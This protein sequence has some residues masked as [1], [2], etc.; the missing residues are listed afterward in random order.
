MDFLILPDDPAAAGPAE[1]AAARLGPQVLT[2]ASG[3][4]WLAGRWAAEDLVIVTAGARRLAVFGRTRLDRDRTERA[5]ANA[6]SLRDLDG[7]FRQLPGAVHLVASFDGRIRAQGSLSTSRQVFHAELGGL[8]VAADSPRLL[9][10]LAGAGLDETTLALRLMVPAPPWPLT[11]RSVWRGV[12]QV[13]AGHWLEIEPAGRG[14]AVPWWT[15]PPADQPLAVVADRLREA[16]L[17]AVSVR[18]RGRRA[19]G[20]DLSGGLDSTSLCFLADAAGAELVTHHWKA[21]DPANDDTAWAERAAARL[22]GSRHRFVEPKDSPSW[23]ESQ[24]D[25]DDRADDVEGPLSWDRNR[26]HM[27]HQAR[28]DAAD[29]A[30]LHL[31]GIGGD[32]LFTTLPTYLWSLVRKHPLRAL[33]AVHQRRVANRWA[34]GATVRGLLDSSPFADSF[35]AAAAVLTDPPTDPS[36]PGL[37]WGGG[38]RRMPEWTTGDTVEAVRRLLRETGE[39]RP[40]PLVGDHVRHQMLEYSVYSGGAI[41]QMRLA[42]DGSGVEWDAP[43]LDD[44]VI[45]AAL[46]ARIEDRAGRGLYKPLLTAAMRGVVPDEILERRTKGEYS[47]EAYDGLRR[48]R[49][50]LLDLCED[51]RLDHLGLV[52]PGPLRT[53]LLDPGAK[54]GQLIPLENTLACETWLRSPSSAPAGSA[55]PTGEPR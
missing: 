26:L 43:F 9:A 1:T 48:N 27:E 29:G 3:R 22:P 50:T 19:V 52:D 34:F 32:E 42:L 33:P 39:A 23:Y 7:V 18:V 2:H 11:L 44:R 20:A 40:R 30:T 53:T 10:G 49:R 14:R 36:D 45:E 46:S 16:L 5:L 51:L 35:A 28:A 6:R 15:P 12:H 21:R 24:A 41:R 55:V 54:L 37:G 17:E 4:P 47:A 8:T 31:V 25:P 13:P 38:W